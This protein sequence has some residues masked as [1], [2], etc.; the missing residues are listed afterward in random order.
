MANH[1]TASGY[2]DGIPCQIITIQATDC[3]GD[4][5]FYEYEINGVF[6]QITSRD[7]LAQWKNGRIISQAP[8]APRLTARLVD[9]VRHSA[10]HLMTGFAGACVWHGFRASNPVHPAAFLRQTK[11]GGVLPAIIAQ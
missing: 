4:C 10:E 7:P 1:P 2:I 5:V 3:L 6:I 8:G 11:G 9:P